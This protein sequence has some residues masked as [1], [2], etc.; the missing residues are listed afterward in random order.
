MASERVQIDR[1]RERERERER[2]VLN[3]IGKQMVRHMSVRNIITECCG[4][5][6]LYGRYVT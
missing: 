3:K 2:E 6:A 1:Q 5:C 4:P